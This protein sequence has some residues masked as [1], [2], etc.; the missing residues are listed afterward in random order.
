MSYA[1]RASNPTQSSKKKTENIF[2][3]NQNNLNRDSSK[4]Y[5]FNNNY[6]DSELG[7]SDCPI[8]TKRISLRRRKITQKEENKLSKMEELSE[9]KLGDLE[10]TLNLKKYLTE[11][12]S[13]NEKVC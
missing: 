12:I 3:D 6:E 1:K 4:F 11:A 10:Y 7:S 13:E 9:D 8:H 2:S 5:F